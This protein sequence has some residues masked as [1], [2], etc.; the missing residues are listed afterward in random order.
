MSKR[1]WLLAG[2]IIVAGATSAVMAALGVKQWWVLAIGAVVGAVAVFFSEYPK[3]F[4][5][6]GAQRR[7]ETGFALTR[8]AVSGKVLDL[9]DPIRLGVHKA[10]KGVP[11]YIRRDVYDEVVSHLRPGGF[12]VLVGDSTAGKSRTAYEAVRATLP[13][14]HL[15]A[16][17][18][19]D[20]VDAAVDDL[21][22]RP[23]C[24]LWLDDL[25]KF[26]GTGGLTVA[27]VD[28]LRHGTIIATLRREEL[29]QLTGG[30]DHR[31]SDEARRVLDQAHQVQ[32]DR[33]FTPAEL[34]RAEEYRSDAQIGD[35]LRNSG[36]YGL[37]EYLAAGPTLLAHWTNAKAPNAHPRGAALVTAA[38]DCRR[39]GFHA[40][41]P[42]ALLDEVHDHYLGNRVRP[43]S[44]NE[45]WKWATEPPRGTTTALLEQGGD[46][47]QV[48]DYLVDHVQ[49]MHA[50]GDHVP[51]DIVLAAIRHADASTA[52]A[53]GQTAYDNGRYALAKSA[54]EHALRLDEAEQ[55]P[56]HLDTVRSR[57]YLA[58]V[59]RAQ[60][61][62]TT[63]ATEYRAVLNIYTRTLGPEHPD[64]LSSRN[65]LANVL[66]DQGDLTAA[67]TEYRA[68]L[69]I[70]TRTLGPEHPHTLTS[71]NNLALVLRAQ[72]DLTA[73]ATEHRAVHDIR[74]RT[75]GPEHPHTLTS[76]NN[77]ANVLYDQGDLTAAATEHRAVHDIRTRTLG[78]EHPHTLRS[79]DNLAL[80]LR[81]QGDL[82]TAATEHRAV[83]NIRTRTLGPEHPHTLT[84]RNNLAEVEKRLR[85]Q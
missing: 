62:L 27:G 50:P 69:N 18:R 61:D 3:E 56:E 24:V 34:E 39:A 15:M 64:T 81:A 35:A 1:G 68:V 13:K 10:A 6:R 7:E 29:N 41:L 8:G 58:M 48:F 80:V 71:R 28:R 19:R 59:L 76:R 32:L 84:S 75:L 2:L 63:A 85:G 16:P 17:E 33:H 38:I 65:N 53:I 55:G 57:H 36:E 72:G 20:L 12:V 9:D 52:Y 11:P 43:E 70:R 51:S 67:A 79:R 4:L 26:V 45:A 82:T 83:L 21:A 40:P 46:H 14:H 60:G 30:D 73:A 42:K 37:A 31:L 77:L 66:Y 25:E 47:V 78:P 54:F 44:L 22:R 23:K 5:K 49:S 74:T